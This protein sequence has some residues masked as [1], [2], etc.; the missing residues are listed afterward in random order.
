MDCQDNLVWTKLWKQQIL[1]RAY[2]LTLV[3]ILSD[4]QL[5]TTQGK[6]IYFFRTTALAI[7][8][9]DE[10]WLMLGIRTGLP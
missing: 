10:T 4:I 7:A 1:S 8:M 2:Q 3:R 9:S 5:A 6:L